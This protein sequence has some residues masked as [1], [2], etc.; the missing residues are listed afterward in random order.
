MSSPPSEQEQS[1]SP[2]QNVFTFTATQAAYMREKKDSYEPASKKERKAI[3]RKVSDYFAAEAE[4][5]TGNPLASE[6][7]KKLLAGV[8]SW[9][10]QNVVK[11]LKEKD[12]WT[13]RW[14]CRL[15]FMKLNRKMIVALSEELVK[16]AV[17]VGRFVKKWE[18]G[19]YE[20]ARNEVG[21]HVGRDATTKGKKGEED[22]WFFNHYQSA[23][24]L[25]MKRLSKE[26]K[27]AYVR[28]AEKW[29][30]Q[31]PPP[32][33]QAR[34]AD[35]SATTKA[36]NF[37]KQM[38]RDG[39]VVCYILL[40]WKSEDGTPV[41]VEMDFGKKLGN[42]R[43]FVTPSNSKT[44]KAA[45]VQFRDYVFEVLGDGGEAADTVA[46]VVKPRTQELIPMAR[47]T[48]G[49]PFLP[50]PGYLT[51][52]MQRG[53]WYRL[54]LRSFFNYSYALSMGTPRNIVGFPS[55]RLVQD[56]R[57]FIDERYMPDDVVDLLKEP[58]DMTVPSLIKVYEHIYDLQE[59]ARKYED[60]AND[61]TF[62]IACFVNRWNEIEER[63]A[64]VEVRE[65]DH[66]EDSEVEMEMFMEDV[67]RKRRAGKDH[68]SKGQGNKGKP[69]ARSKDTGGARKKAKGKS[70]A[71]EKRKASGSTRHRKKGKPSTPTETS[72]EE[73]PFEKSA[74]ESTSV[75]L[76]QTLL[77]PLN[78]EC[79]RVSK[80]TFH[81]GPLALVI[82]DLINIGNIWMILISDV[83][84]ALMSNIM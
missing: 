21:E 74:S 24:T 67:R 5:Q 50:S 22:D 37:M 35:K 9:F 59:D 58:S 40:G 62:E 31:G 70:S 47:N 66:E 65:G 43:D 42:P 75:T 26:E 15:V 33:E 30:L 81:L 64:R 71:P 72:E 8:R 29:R 34:F 63:K 18:K 17:D 52:K 76:G 55:T 32:D 53:E 38:R 16:G 39:N 56:R 48:F 6:A 83:I 77:K 51:A 19:D 41:A 46:P 57:V 4:R 2:E 36:F 12:V 1:D 7:K 23:T 49:E 28:I 78:S 60:N 84:K 61:L 11:E 44:M 73:E 14:N 25:L 10:K 80:W 54:A 69:A 20:A 27:E 3:A 82:N 68:P 79:P 45:M 13:I